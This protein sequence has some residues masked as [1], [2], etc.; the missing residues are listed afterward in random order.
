MLSRPK[1]SFRF[2]W[3]HLTAF[4][5]LFSHHH[6]NPSSH[7][8]FLNY[9]RNLP[10]KIHMVF[11]TTARIFLSK[12]KFWLYCAPFCLSWGKYQWLPNAFSVKAKILIHTLILACFSFFR[13]F[14]FE[15][16]FIYNAVPISAVQ[17]SD[18]VIHIYTFLSYA[19]FHY[20]LSQDIE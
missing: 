13:Q 3:Q 11:H 8:L 9:C 14:F 6:H 10:S 17:Q 4:Y 2:F 1:S 16:E 19:P 12:C 18:S 7:P 15:V 20:G 5:S